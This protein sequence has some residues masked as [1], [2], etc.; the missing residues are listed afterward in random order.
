[1]CEKFEKHRRSDNSI[2]LVSLLHAE[3]DSAFINN[4]ESAETYLKL[5]ESI[6]PIISKQAAAI[7]IGN[8]TLM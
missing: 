2:D 8:A 7:A 1:M 3:I 6:S 5:I 4:I